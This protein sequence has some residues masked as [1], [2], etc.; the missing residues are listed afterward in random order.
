MHARNGFW[1]GS[2]DEKKRK[3]ERITTKHSAAFKREDYKASSLHL[4]EA[5][6]I[7]QNYPWAWFRLGKKERKKERKNNVIL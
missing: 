5:L 7:N 3:K 1:E 6:S 4:N 2:R